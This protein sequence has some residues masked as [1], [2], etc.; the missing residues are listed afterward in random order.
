[1]EKG[2]LVL[3]PGIRYSVD[4]P[5]LYYTSVAFSYAGYE[6][7]PVDSYDVKTT[8]DLGAYAD[9]ATKNLVKRLRDV[10]FEKYEHVVFAEKSIGTVIGMMLEDALGLPNVTH[11]IYTPLDSTFT[12][13]NAKRRI[14]GIAAGTNDKHIEIKALRAAC[15]K[16]NLPLTEIKN[17]G[18]RLEGGK[19]VTKDISAVAQVI[20]SIADP[21]IIDNIAKKEAE[22]KAA[23]EKKAAGPIK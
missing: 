7:L 21:K 4:C 6:I 17:G 22:E 8:E 23:A 12:Y 18:H 19:D 10:D 2:L 15:R 11:I 1:M 9:K 20:A 14:A 5:L 3:L 13:L 16:L